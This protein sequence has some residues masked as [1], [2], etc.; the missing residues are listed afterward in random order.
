MDLKD[1][2]NNRSCMFLPVKILKA[3]IMEPFLLPILIPLEPKYSLQDP[4]FTEYLIIIITIY[5]EKRSEG[6][7]I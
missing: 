6:L 3:L 4:V 1:I 7:S 5:D 2:D